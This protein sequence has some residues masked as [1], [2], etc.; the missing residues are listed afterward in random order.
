MATDN[1]PACRLI[2][3]FRRWFIIHENFP[4]P[5]VSKDPVTRGD[6]EIPFTIF[7]NVSYLSP[8]KGIGIERIVIEE[9]EIIAVIPGQTIHESKPDE[10]QVVLEKYGCIFKF[11]VIDLEFLKQQLVFLSDIKKRDQEK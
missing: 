10:T 8:G 3:F 9:L 11:P 6:P 4:R 5:D 7:L 1:V 2:I